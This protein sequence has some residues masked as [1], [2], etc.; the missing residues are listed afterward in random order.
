MKKIAWVSSLAVLLIVGI[1]LFSPSKTHKVHKK[2]APEQT[3]DCFLFFN[4][5]KL[6]EM[7]LNELNDS[8]DK[9]VI[10][11]AME[12]FTGKP[13]PL[14]FLQHRHLF[15][16]FE[17]KII[18]IPVERFK[19]VSAWDRE[20][21]QRNQIARGLIN[22]K[23]QDIIILS[24]LDE[25]IRSNKIPLMK[26]YLSSHPDSFISY[27]LSMYRCFVNRTVPDLPYWV[28]PVAATYKQ[29]KKLNAQKMRDQRL[30][31]PMIVKKG[32]WHFSSMGGHKMWCEKVEGFSHTEVD[33]PENKD[34]V[35]LFAAIK[36]L[37]LVPIDESYPIFIQKNQ[38]ELKRLGFISSV[39]DE[40]YPP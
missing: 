18:Y 5:L 6:L 15:K 10:V 11:E 7:R 24:D 1:F 37:P 27:E 31:S 35:K 4:E 28:G 9:F 32:G 13:K 14:N 16:Q 3:Y 12:T 39:E 26:E 29:F 20:T 17:E 40:A 30:D 8:V 21:F 38:T 33:T 34:P 36:D 22:C 23:K 19:A 25:I 2:R